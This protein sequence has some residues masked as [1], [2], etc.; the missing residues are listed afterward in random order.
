V[1]R[2][3]VDLECIGARPNSRDEANCQHEDIDQ[4]QTSQE[5]GIEN[6]QNEVASGNPHYFAPPIESDQQG[7]RKSEE[8]SDRLP[9]DSRGEPSTGERTAALAWVMLILLEIQ[10]IVQEVARTRKHAET[11]QDR[12]DREPSVMIVRIAMEK[13]SRQAEATLNPML[14]PQ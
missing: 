14:H 3:I 10:Q 12:Q 13:E 11:D 9:R 7:H 5:G 2:E 6:L 8:N 1:D 4:G